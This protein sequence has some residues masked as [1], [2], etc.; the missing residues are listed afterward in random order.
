[1]NQQTEET[2]TLHVLVGKSVIINTEARLR[3]VMLS[4]PMV[5]EASTVS[6][7]QVVLT[8]KAAG[9]SNLILWDETER[10]RILDV[11]VD[12]DVSQLRDAIQ[13]AFPSEPIQV[14]TEQ[15]RVVVSGTVS[16]Q[17]VIDSVMNMASL[18]SDRVVNSFTLVPPPRDRQI[19]LQV[20]FAEVDRTKLDQLGI[21]ILSTGAA[22]T[23]GS[24]STQQFGSQTLGGGQ[25]GSSIGAGLQGTTS[26][27][28]INDLLNIFLF[29]TDLNLAA[30]I[31]DLQQRS[32][33][34]ILAEPNL[35]AINGRPATFLAGG[36][37]P[38]P[39]VQGGTGVT[40]VTIQFRP[41]GVR[42]DFTGIITPDD[43][44]RLRVVPEVSTLD[45]T[46]ALTISGFLVP[47][48]STRRAETEIELK[49]GQSF[50]IAGLMDQR[51]QA[52]LSKIPG[53]GDIP[54]LGMLFRSRSLQQSRTEL[55]VLVTPQIAD[56]VQQDLPSPPPPASALRDLDVPRFDRGLPD[57]AE[58]SE[59]ERQ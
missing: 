45:F 40:A 20:R 54:I 50:G 43:T 8:A 39:V 15:G 29:R 36:E 16:S 3:R 59:S 42:L 13:Q 28:T 52:Q 46:N 17:S 21:N 9:S 11:L 7:T 33:L 24:L 53:I 27:F 35:L 19:L 49:D 51:T 18:F 26:T 30:T 25:I 38:F 14:E 44:I 22:N 32:V 5:A 34:Q 10:S 1:M 37:F 6:P 55:L 57:S 48:I 47:A 56:P 2:Q 4:N 23:P 12:V 31:R 58:P 41:F